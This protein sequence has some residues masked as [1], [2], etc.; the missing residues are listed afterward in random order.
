MAAGSCS[1][2]IASPCRYCCGSTAALPNV[3]RPSVGAGGVATGCARRKRSVVMSPSASVTVSVY[4][5]VGSAPVGVP[6]IVPPSAYVTAPG[7]PP[8]TGGV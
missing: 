8:G 3:G 2:T 4:S 1:A 7:I 6:P 5:W